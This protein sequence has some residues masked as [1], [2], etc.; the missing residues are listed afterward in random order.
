MNIRRI[1]AAL[2]GSVVVGG[3]A[4]CG[5]GGG[6][7]AG[8]TTYTVG[9]TLA[10]SVGSVTLRLNGA[11][12][13]VV[14]NSGSF[15]FPAGV[16]YLANYAVTVSNSAQKCNVQNGS[17][18]MGTANVTNVT[19][20]CTTVI[21]SAILN[22]ASEN[23][24]NA[25]TA[26]GRG[27]VIV[28]PTTLEITGGITFSGVVATNQHIH[29]APP[30]NP[31]GN[32]GVLVGLTLAPDGTTATVPA[33]TVLTAAQ[34]TALLA[35]EL[36]FNVHSA[37]N[38][39]PPAATCAAGEI[40]GQINIQGGVEAGLATLNAAQEVPP[41][42]SAATGR[43][44]VVVDSATGQVLI[45]YTTHNVGANTSNAHIHLGATGVSG[46]VRLPLAFGATIATA[47]QGA[48]M[49]ASDITAL[50]AGN[51]YFNVHSTNNL[52]APAATCGAGE[53]RGQITP[54]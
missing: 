46:G 18:T 43:G 22:G 45:G 17:G 42:T 2:L 20:T 11:N 36:Y 12:D 32:G 10:G 30:G 34:Y 25:S 21:R 7:G 37:N 1:F 27:A 8:T 54:Q 40:R 51:L 5:G 24:P 16:A 6:G 52:C 50:T 35:G 28:N 15:T 48:I 14:A 23:P 38:L 39:C 41:G 29:Q 47:A 4:S 3:I 13:L 53:I 44:T 19:V 33:G 26:T 9:G 49:P 31:T